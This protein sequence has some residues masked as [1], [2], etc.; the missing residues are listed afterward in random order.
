MSDNVISSLKASPLTFAIEVLGTCA[1]LGYLS[2]LGLL[3]Q[4]VYTDYFPS[5][6]QKFISRISGDC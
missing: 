1:F 3:H 2:L 4:N 6:Q 5:K